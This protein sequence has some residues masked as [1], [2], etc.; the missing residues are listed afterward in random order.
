MIQFFANLSDDNAADLAR[1]VDPRE[2]VLLSTPT[3]TRRTLET[4]LTIK[5]RQV[6][7]AADNGNTAA[8]F[9]IA[10]EFAMRAEELKQ[11]RE[12]ETRH[13]MGR[14]SAPLRAK[15]RT[16]AIDVARRC[17][18]FVLT[19]RQKAVLATQST[20]QPDFFTCLEDLTIPVLIQLDVE[21]IY[22][23]LRRS[24]FVA[25]QDRGLR[26]VDDVIKGRFGAVVGTPYA[27][28]HAFDYDSA[29]QVGAQSAKIDRL[30]GIACGLA[31]FLNDRNYVNQYIL[32]G[33][34]IWVKGRR[35][36][37]H[38]YLRMLLVTLGMLD[39][40]A[41]RRSRIPP[42]HGLGAGA[43]IV[44][45]LLSLCA[46]GSPLLSVDST[47]PE[48]NASIGKLFV[49]KP[50]P[51]TV[52]VT[53]VAQ[54][55]LDGRRTWDCPCPY[56][57]ALEREIPFDIDAARRYYEAHI[58]PRKIESDDLRTDDGIGRFLS[59]CW[60][61]RNEPAERLIYRA[62]VNHSQ[63]AVT[64]IARGL[65]ERSASYSELREWVGT[66]CEAYKATAEPTFALQVEECL[67][68]IDR[69]RPIT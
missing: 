3:A 46:Y 69:L 19:E 5:N 47:A 57:A 32:N 2:A 11:Q 15:F 48:K 12:L 20:V 9:R 27:T 7:L 68:L 18:E 33:R 43:P 60:E 4:A 55:L 28:L 35:N 17:G 36:V 22:T 44:L 40:F 1:E 58:A 52:S 34:R 31:S 62:R 65:R 23:G 59:I 61:T 49:N 26:L 39:G 8:I 54:A 56:C 16:L 63:W 13:T 66:Q 10:N 64:G 30:G 51:L 38:R 37:P 67:R 25:L 24:T 21:R 53:G 45:P 41:S 14:P 29:Y 50:G 42:F 6:P